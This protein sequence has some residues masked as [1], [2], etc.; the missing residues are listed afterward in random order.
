MGAIAYPRQQVVV[1]QVWSPN[2]VNEVLVEIHPDLG[3]KSYGKIV[4]HV[5][6]WSV[7]VY[8]KLTMML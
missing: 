8:M 5:L 6:H 2:C 7:K 1:R 4:I 3:V